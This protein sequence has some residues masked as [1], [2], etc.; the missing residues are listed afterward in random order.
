MS[1]THSSCTKGFFLSL[2]MSRFFVLFFGW[3]RISAKNDTTSFNHT[4]Q[5]FVI[6]F[7]LADHWDGE[8]GALLL[9]Q[10]L[11]W[12]K[13]CSRF[14]VVR[15]LIPD[16]IPRKWL[17]V[18]FLTAEGG[19]NRE[20][21]MSPVQTFCR[22]EHSVSCDCIQVC[23]V[24]VWQWAPCCVSEFLVEFQKPRYLWVC[25]CMYKKLYPP[26]FLFFL[27]LL[28]LNWFHPDITS[29]V[30]WMGV[31][32]QISYLSPALASSSYS[33]CFFR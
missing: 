31:E 20:C 14:F 17:F 32:S 33:S 16:P 29:V 5:S 15:G 25:I 8:R 12:K 21:G 11:H 7:N 2:N 18:S 27:P 23:E 19:G 22:S 4:E 6:K 26:Y 9:L 24:V 1:L 10:S 3:V 30:S 13:T 28:L